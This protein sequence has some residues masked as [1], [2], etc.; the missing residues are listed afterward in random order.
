MGANDTLIS[1][2]NRK[3]Y[4]AFKA[5]HKR[6]WTFVLAGYLAIYEF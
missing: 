5:K 6:F 3:M 4:D 1:Y 2:P